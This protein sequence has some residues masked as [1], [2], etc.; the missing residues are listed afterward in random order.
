[1]PEAE[2]ALRLGFWLLDHE[3]PS[4]HVDIALDG[5]H[6]RVRSHRASSRIV[7]DRQVFD[8]ETFLR[9]NGCSQTPGATDWRGEYI[10]RGSTLSIKSARGFDVRAIREGRA[11]GVE[12]KGGPLQTI[13]GR[14]P[15]AILAIAIGQ[16]IT[17]PSASKV[18]EIWVAVPDSSQF[19]RAGR[20][21]ASTP[22]FVKTG[23]RI[24]LVGG[25]DEVRFLSDGL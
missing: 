6:V 20:T 10:R 16:A 3:G 19:E 1:M 12:C 22:A 4:S 17:D 13:K 14:S 24:A 15:R 11:I 8:I 23:I 18:R 2:V 25:K 5:A 9:E 7:K 21:I